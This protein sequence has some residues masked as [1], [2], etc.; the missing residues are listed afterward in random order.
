MGTPG[1]QAS[2]SDLSHEELTLLLGLG[3]RLV[4]ELDLDN[5]LAL[6]AETA[7]QVVQA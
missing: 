2:P 3:E 7:C 1:D 6:V 4:A 5:V